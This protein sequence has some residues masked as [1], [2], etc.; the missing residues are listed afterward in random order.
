MAVDASHSQEFGGPRNFVL[1][2]HS[3]WN[4]PPRL[5]HQVTDLLRSRGDS[6]VFF[7]RARYGL[8]RARIGPSRERLTLV[9]SRKLVHSQL[10][11]LPALHELNRRFIVPQLR[12]C[13]AAGLFGEDPWI[14]NFNFDYYF[15]RDV[16]PSRPI[17]TIINDDFEAQS[18]LPFHGHLTW[19]LE[20]TCR[21]SDRV[22]ALSE[23]LRARLAPWCP[24]TRLFLPWSVT[25][26]VG[27]CRSDS[28]RD[29]LL[30]WGSVDRAIDLQVLDRLARELHVDRPDFR[31]L[32]VGPM[33]RRFRGPL[34]AVAS[35]RGNIDIIGPTPLGQLPLDRV[36]AAIIPYRRHPVQDA[37][38][39]ANKSFQL[40]SRGLPIL[41]SGMPDFLQLPFVLRLDAGMGVDRL[42]R[43]T[44][45]RFD[46]WQADMRAFMEA[47][48]PESRLDALCGSIAPSARG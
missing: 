41:I 2:T 38:T 25:P 34:K 11:V 16:F 8:P 46:P 9:G 36:L 42:L 15:L 28:S 6:V 5:R 10:R 19:A 23:R 4:E 22:L 44:A 21:S 39:L 14:V 13:A 24:D 37:I 31:V 1:F 35:A 32:I 26:Y 3:H 17:I 33:A 30:F 45:E 47:N 29:R 40:I 48:P 27:P 43:I 20:R 18:R 7:E 12:E